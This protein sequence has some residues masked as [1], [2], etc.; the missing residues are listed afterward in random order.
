MTYL[1]RRELTSTV[2]FL[3]CTTVLLAAPSA[4]P[5]TTQP[6]ASQPAGPLKFVVSFDP[7]IQSTPYTGRVWIMTSTIQ[8]RDP[9]FGPDWFSPEPF[10]S[11]EVKDWKPNTPLEIADNAAAFPVPISQ[12]PAKRFRIQAVMDLAGDGRKHPGAPGNGYSS[13]VSKRINPKTSGPIELKIRHTAPQ[14][15]MLEDDRIKSVEIESK[16]LSKFFGKPTKIRAALCL[17]VG[18]DPKGPLRYPTV[19]DIPGFGGDPRQVLIY[20]ARPPKTDQPFVYIV[21]DPNCPLGHHVFAD[22]ANN[23]PWGQAFVEE[24]IPYLEKEFRLVPEPRARF[25]TGHSSGGWSSLWLQIT[26]PDYFG[27]VWSMAPDP[28]DFRD[29]T[30]INLYAPGENAF[31]DREGKARHIARLNGVPILTVRDFFNMESAEGPGGQMGSFEAVFSPRGPDGRPLELF[32]RKTGAINPEV[33]KAWENYDINLVLRKNW[34]ELGPKLA[35]K[36]HIIVGDTDT[37]YLEGAVRLLEK[38]LKELG[39]DA[40]VT[41]VPGKDHMNLPFAP[42]ATGRFAQMAD[43]YQATTSRPATAP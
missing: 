23:G 34:K 31:K 37:F 40:E 19:Y 20:R 25:L 14:P 27:G 43:K 3:L 29:F 2:C 38:T 39:S 8:R 6:A 11:V 10:A 30:G 33:A 17:P 16:L 12:W 18:Y 35:G 26:H 21:P 7:A 5:A 13:V 9:R 41:I 28:V 36:I 22:S 15:K 1:N 4:Q 42:E 24:L 32:D